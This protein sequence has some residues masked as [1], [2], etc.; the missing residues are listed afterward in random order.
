MDRSSASGTVDLG[1]IPSRVK[2]KTL[3]LVFAASLLHV[4]HNGDSVE[5]KP[6]SL[7]VVPLGKTLG[8][9]QPS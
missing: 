8:K 6:A 5:N 7:L 1:V 9:I 2:P 4:Q 3:E